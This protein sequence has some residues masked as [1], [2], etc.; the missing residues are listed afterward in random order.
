MDVDY[1]FVGVLGGRGN[2]DFGVDGPGREDLGRL[3]VDQ[4][5]IDLPYAAVGDCGRFPGACVHGR[6]EM[7]IEV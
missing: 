3:Q 4:V 7:V 2:I 1:G 6:S 5:E